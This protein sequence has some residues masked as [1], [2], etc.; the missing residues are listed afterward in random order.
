V[1]KVGDVLLAK[2]SAG[3]YEA[4]WF[5]MVLV[6][7][8]SKYGFYRVILLNRKS[9]LGG[10]SGKIINMTKHNLHKDYECLR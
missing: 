6:V 8:I 10:F 1:F 3:S 2:D 7:E 5:T 9:P 4:Y